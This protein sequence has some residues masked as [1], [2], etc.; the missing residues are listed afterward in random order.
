MQKQMR[1]RQSSLID[2]VQR[3]HPSRVRR[4]IASGMDVNV[5]DPQGY[6]ALMHAAAKG[7][8]GIVRLLM[9]HGADS[10][11]EAIDWHL[12]WASALSVAA[13]HGHLNVVRILL[14]RNRKPARTQWMR[15]RDAFR[16]LAHQPGKKR[17]VLYRDDQRYH[18]APAFLRFV[19]FVHAAKGKRPAAVAMLRPY[20][21][22]GLHVHKIATNWFIS[23]V[24]FDTLDAVKFWLDL[25]VEIDTPTTWGQSRTALM[26][27]AWQGNIA[28]VHLLLSRGADV[29]AK[30]ADGYTVFDMFELMPDPLTFHSIDHYKHFLSLQPAYEEIRRLLQEQVDVS[31]K[32]QDDP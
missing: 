29:N 28:M 24:E 15:P 4:L 22:Y 19:A 2:A 11:I 8:T 20:E 17:V 12:G 16:V 30:T 5:C 31:Q 18:A 14:T 26:A 13:H 27:A 10:S 1:K 6:T 21:D 3:C 25:G 9:T 23:A 7:R 32:A